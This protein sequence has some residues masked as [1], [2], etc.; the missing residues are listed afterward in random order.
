MARR[1]Q[2]DEQALARRPEALPA[3]VRD[4]WARQREE[5]AGNSEALLRAARELLAE[6]GASALDVRQVARRAGVG[7][8]TVYRRYGDK[9][10]LLAALLDDDERELQDELLRGPPPL[11]P[12]AP[13]P[14]RLGAFLDALVQLTDEHLDLLLA[15]EAA[16]PGARLRVGAYGAWR[17]HLAALAREL[18]PGCDAEWIATLL[19][20]P[21]DAQLFLHQKRALG[22]EPAHIAVG[23]REVALALLAP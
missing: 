13:A 19:L 7:V 21:L 4:G 23:L 18:R 1:S 3:P 9:A 11:G 17:M 8:G 6:G 14:Q 15:T 22:R 2:A 12:D 10:G 20:A 5:A 16:A